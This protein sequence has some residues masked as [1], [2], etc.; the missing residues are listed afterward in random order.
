VLILTATTIGLLAGMT[1][2]IVSM[3]VAAFLILAVYAAAAIFSGSAS[4][5]ELLVAILGYNF[6][7]TMLVI[8]TAVFESTK[9]A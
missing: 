9:Q 7:L 6:G 8:G 1:R 5:I 2:S 3:I 4:L